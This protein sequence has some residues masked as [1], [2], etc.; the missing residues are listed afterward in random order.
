MSGVGEKEMRSDQVTAVLYA[1]S[2]LSFKSFTLTCL[3]EQLEYEGYAKKD[4][5]VAVDSLKVD[6]AKQAVTKAAGYLDVSAVSRSGLVDLLEFEGFSA[7]HATVAVDSITVSRT[8]KV[9][10]SAKD[11]LGV[12]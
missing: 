3:I 10:A 9:V 8:V 2:Y 7:K 4:A 1:K 6:W 12:L 5:E 11:I